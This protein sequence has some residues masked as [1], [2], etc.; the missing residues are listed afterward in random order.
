MVDAKGFMRDVPPNAPNP[1]SVNLADV[2]RN[3][4]VSLGVNDK[5]I[6]LFFCKIH[7]FYQTIMSLSGRLE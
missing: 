5:K 3:V 1:K 4:S 6:S 2:K 7:Y